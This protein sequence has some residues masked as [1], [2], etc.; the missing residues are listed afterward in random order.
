MI[1]DAGRV[2]WAATVALHHRRWHA[3]RDVD[4]SLIGIA[5]YG[6]LAD[7]A[8]HDTGQTRGQMIRILAKPGLD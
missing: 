8:F 4:A 5:F 2:R 1:R 7:V 3:P 6:E